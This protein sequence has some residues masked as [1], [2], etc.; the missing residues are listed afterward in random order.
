MSRVSILLTPGLFSRWIKNNFIITT[1]YGLELT[2][3]FFKT[4]QPS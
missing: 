3:C 4:G 2:T 1:P